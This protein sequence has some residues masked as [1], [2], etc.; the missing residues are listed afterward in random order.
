[1]SEYVVIVSLVAL[2]SILFLPK[3][4]PMPPIAHPEVGSFRASASPCCC[5]GP[6]ALQPLSLEFGADAQKASNN[7]HPTKLSASKHQCAKA[8]RHLQK[9]PNLHPRTLNPK[10]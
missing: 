9:F 7:V 8:G 1:M 4:L 3:K 10:P 5:A 6:E 2:L